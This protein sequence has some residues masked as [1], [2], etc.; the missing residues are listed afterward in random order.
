[1]LKMGIFIGK[2]SINDNLHEIFDL[3]PWKRNNRRK[4]GIYGVS[5]IKKKT[6][7]PLVELHENELCTNIQENELW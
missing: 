2:T 3:F 1:M 5:K 4:M 7:T 6:W